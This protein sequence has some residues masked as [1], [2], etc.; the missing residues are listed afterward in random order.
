MGSPRDHRPVLSPG[1]NSLSLGSREGNDLMPWGAIS[2][3]DK[4]C[5]PTIRPLLYSNVDALVDKL[6][7]EGHD[8]DAEKRQILALKGEQAHDLL[9]GL[10]SVSRHVSI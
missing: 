3:Y 2:K 4:S 1:P 6:W 5:I 10:Q 8:R 9:D 7:S